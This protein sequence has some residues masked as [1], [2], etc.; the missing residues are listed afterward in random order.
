MYAQAD[1]QYVGSYPNGFPNTPGTTTRSATYAVVPSYEN[2]NLA[3]GWLKNNFNVSLYAQNVLDNQ[4]PIFIDAASY[5]VNRYIT[6]RPRTIGI[7]LTW[8]D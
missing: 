5:S 8:S 4:T 7:R 6:L 1:V 2:V 3:V